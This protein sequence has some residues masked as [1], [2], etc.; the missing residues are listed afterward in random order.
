MNQIINYLLLAIFIG[1]CH[2]VLALKGTPMGGKGCDRHRGN[3]LRRHFA[4]PVSAVTA[5][6]RWWPH[7]F[8]A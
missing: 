6:Q 1:I 5:R 3:A 7:P 2:T 4:F 8:G